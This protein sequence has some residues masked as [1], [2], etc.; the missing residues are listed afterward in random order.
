MDYKII[1]ELIALED[2]T[3]DQKIEI[4][5]NIT[6]ELE[7]MEDL[8]SEAAITEG[9]ELTGWDDFRAN[10]ARVAEMGG[11]AVTNKFGM[12]KLLDASAKKILVQQT[13]SGG[14]GR[15]R[16]RRIPAYLH[17]RLPSL[18]LP[19]A[20]A[21]VTVMARTALENYGRLYPKRMERDVELPEA[22]NQAMQASLGWLLENQNADGS[23]NDVDRNVVASEVN[24]IQT[25]MAICGLIGHVMLHG[26]SVEIIAPIKKG[27]N[28]LA[29]SQ[30]PSFG[31]WSAR[32]GQNG[33]EPDAKATSMAVFAS[34]MADK[35]LN[36]SSPLAGE[37]TIQ[38]VEWLLSNQL[39]I[40]N[41]V[42]A[43]NPDSFL[44]GIYYCIEALVYYRLLNSSDLLEHPERMVR[45]RRA[46]RRAIRWYTKNNRLVRYEDSIGWGWKNGDRSGD[47][48]NT[49]AAI[50]VLL[51]CAEEDFSFVIQ[52]GIEYLAKQAAPDELWDGD[53][54]LV[55]Y[56]LMKY[57]KP[58][59][60]SHNELPLLLQAH[61]G[62]L[63]AT[64]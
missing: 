26:E 44:Y 25:C 61:K 34:L 58:E 6:L 7:K 23:W 60:R 59:F 35:C 14:W 5:K 17:E 22:I 40:G 54:A 48:A 12:E 10:E 2:L 52:R 30:N 29:A 4:L 31:G 55:M 33:A 37:M 15:T 16:L 41:W 32:P 50:T 39:P 9:R 63:Y 38:A 43:E 49:A 11:L 21:W 51:D 57:L 42:Y 36:L 45:I 28:F 53:T 46:I 24:I 1:Q 47:I 62:G 56:S 19:V 8:E 13:E 27:L 20:S 3:S 64:G 18:A